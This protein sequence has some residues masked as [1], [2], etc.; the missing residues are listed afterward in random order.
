MDIHPVL[1]CNQATSLQPHA[2][3]PHTW[4]QQ[5]WAVQGAG[6]VHRI[7][8]AHP[9]SIISFYMYKPCTLFVN[10]MDFSDTFIQN[11][12][13]G[14]MRPKVFTA[15]SREGMTAISLDFI[16]FAGIISSN[17]IPYVGLPFLKLSAAQAPFATAATVEIGFFSPANTLP[18]RITIG[19]ACTK[20]IL[21]RELLKGIPWESEFEG[22]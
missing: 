18:H 17:E 5:M 11:L 1:L 12:G 22:R 2:C 19:M 9:N 6:S 21:T 15:N 16:N 7:Q 10:L 13:L 3:K 20:A 14:L 8:Q 4:S